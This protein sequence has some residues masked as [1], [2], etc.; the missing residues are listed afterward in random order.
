MKKFVLIS[1]TTVSLLMACGAGK[2]GE[3]GCSNCA[4][5][6]KPIAKPV[7]METKSTK[8]GS[9]FL[10]QNGLPHMTKLVKENW[11]NPSLGLTKAQKEKLLVVRE[12][13]LGMVQRVTPQIAALRKEIRKGSYAG[14]DNQALKAKVEQ[15][16]ALQIEATLGHLSCIA[17][18]KTILTPKQA[19]FLL[20]TM[21]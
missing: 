16:A 4:K 14:I 13:V 18:T 9:P 17:Q 1:A 11:G 15:L 19:T 5:G 12:N 3:S 8:K 10:V 2:N 20:S 7:K 21:K 6:E